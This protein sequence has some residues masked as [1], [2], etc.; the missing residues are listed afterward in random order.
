MDTYCVVFCSC[1][2]VFPRV[3]YNNTDYPVWSKFCV[4][5]LAKPYLINACYATPT[6]LM[7]LL[8]MHRFVKNR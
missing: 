1:T 2:V 7:H 5:A 3:D 6:S 4:Y 8:G